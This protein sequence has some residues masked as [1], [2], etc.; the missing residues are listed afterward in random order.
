MKRSILYVVAASLF[1]G[2]SSSTQAALRTATICPGKGVVYGGNQEGTLKIFLSSTK[3]IT[4]KILPEGPSGSGF[5][6]LNPGL[7]YKVSIEAITAMK[8]TLDVAAS[9]QRAVKL[10]YDDTKIVTI[11]NGETGYQLW[12]ITGPLSLANSTNCAQP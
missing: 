9:I 7:T 11:S 10:Y 8:S 4:A 12:S 2:F 3:T 6:V 5:E 1:L